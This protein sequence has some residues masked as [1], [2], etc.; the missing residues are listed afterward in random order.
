VHEYIRHHTTRADVARETAWVIEEYR[1]AL[2]R[3]GAL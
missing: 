2:D 1:E 3:L